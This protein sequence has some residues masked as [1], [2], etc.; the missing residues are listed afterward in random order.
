MVHLIRKSKTCAQVLQSQ[1]GLGPCG[2][3]WHAGPAHS[4]A[5]PLERL[6]VAIAVQPR[7]PALREV[8]A[9]LGA[10]GRLPAR[11]LRPTTAVEHL[12]WA[13]LCTP[14]R[15]EAGQVAKEA[16]PSPVR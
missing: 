13:E 9:S 6:A 8:N 4:L 7:Q 15:M 10:A 12:A 1:G 16:N 5:Q 2:A 14:N 3:G 11:A